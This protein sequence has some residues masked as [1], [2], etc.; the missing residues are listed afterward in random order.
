MQDPQQFISRHGLRYVHTITYG[1]SF[2][3]S[4][5]LNSKETVSDRDIGAFADFSV[6]TGLFTV[7]GSTD[8]QEALSQSNLNVS[9]FI[10]AQWT[11]GSGIRQDYHSP[12]TLNNMF[13][14]WDGSWRANPAPITII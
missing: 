4:V 8:F 5:T 14:D 3:G 6:N 13:Q 12:E 1:G 2:L 7:G 10:N 9:L 11:G